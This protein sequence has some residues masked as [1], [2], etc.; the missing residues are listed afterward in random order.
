MYYGC[1]YSW[2]SFSI[3]KRCAGKRERRDIDIRERRN[4]GGGVGRVR[5]S[6]DR[7]SRA[8]GAGT[9]GGDPQAGSS[10][11]LPDVRTGRWGLRPLEPPRIA[12]SRGNLAD[13]TLRANSIR[14]TCRGSLLTIVAS[15]TSEGEICQ[16][17]H[18]QM[19]PI[20]IS[21]ISSLN[22]SKNDQLDSTLQHLYNIILL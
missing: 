13:G 17:Y 22:L 2:G 18:P 9:G 4:N 21:I 10:G 16:R 6:R 15:Q 14:C 12:A 5:S 20:Y 19:L 11:A 1:V 7:I 3:T 8:G